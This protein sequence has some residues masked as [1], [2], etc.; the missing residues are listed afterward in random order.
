MCETSTCHSTSPGHG[1]VFCL[2]EKGCLTTIECTGPDTG[3]PEGN[4]A[5]VKNSYTH[6]G[7]PQGTGNFHKEV[8]HNQV[9]AKGSA[10]P[11]EPA[12]W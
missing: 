4:T 11:E 3:L 8:G 5:G 1:N 7:S 2:N 6:L 9:L 12:E 10:G